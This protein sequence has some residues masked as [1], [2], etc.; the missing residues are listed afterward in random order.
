MSSADAHLQDTEDSLCDH[1]EPVDPLC[2]KCQI[3]S[4]Q[5]EVERLQSDIDLAELRG[6]EWFK[7]AVLALPREGPMDEGV[8]EDAV[9]FNL[10]PSAVVEAARLKGE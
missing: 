8:L 3:V 10:S 4:L 6:A 5:A 1:G 2:D 7:K 9:K